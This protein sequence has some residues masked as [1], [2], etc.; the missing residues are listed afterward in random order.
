MNGRNPNILIPIDAARPG[1]LEHCGFDHN[2]QEHLLKFEYFLF[3]VLFWTY[4]VSAE[5]FVLRPSPLGFV[6]RV[7]ILPRGVW[8]RVCFAHAPDLRGRVDS[9]GWVGYDYTVVAIS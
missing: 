4:S 8:L 1:D 9:S 7:G 3:G 5:Y 2:I 6:P